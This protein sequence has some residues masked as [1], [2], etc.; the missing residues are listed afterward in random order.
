MKHQGFDSEDRV[1]QVDWLHQE[2]QGILNYGEGTAD[3]LVDFWKSQPVEI[4]AWF[5]ASDERL[6][7]RFVAEALG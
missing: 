5:D 6:L 2:A 1:Q 3:E 4:P 7:R